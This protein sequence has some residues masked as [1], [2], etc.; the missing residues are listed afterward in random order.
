[1]SLLLQ[2]TGPVVDM[3]YNVR[4]LPPSG[5]EAEV[6]GFS[7][8]PGGGFNAMVAARAAGMA[9]RLGGS[10]GSGP[11]AAMVAAELQARGISL[12][13]PALKDRDQGCC[14]VLLEPDG[15]RSFISFPGAE[16]D[17]SRAALDQIDLSA[18]SHVM[19]S[20]YSLHYPQARRDLAGW[21]AQ[22][23]R[24]ITVVFDPSPVAGLLDPAYLQPVLA[25]A[26]WISANADEAAVLSGESEALPALRALA[27]NRP[28]AVLRQG[29][30]GCLLCTGDQVNQLPAHR[31]AAID[32]NGAGDCHIGSFIAELAASGDALRAARY[33]NIAAALSTTRPGPATA[34]ARAEVEPLL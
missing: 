20:G 24:A 31:V 10:L 13:R 22:L 4:A 7:M 27:A 17:I 12:A 2:L 26:D 33:A 21:I 18:V 25:R 23:P 9:V 5:G 14:T 30:N 8:A 6:S 1:M 28:G 32:T 15:E 11:M 34:P 19:L 16:G 29:A 3:I